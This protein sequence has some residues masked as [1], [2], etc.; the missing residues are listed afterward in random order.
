[1]EEKVVEEPKIVEKKE[2]HVNEQ[3]KFLKDIF[4]AELKEPDP[5]KYVAEIPEKLSEGD[6]AMIQ[7]TA[8]YCAKNGKNFLV[9]LSER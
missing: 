3:Q 7:H 1:M 9:A 8:Q 6:Q 5:Q 4:E 2:E